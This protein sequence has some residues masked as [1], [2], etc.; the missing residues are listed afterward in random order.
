MGVAIHRINRMKEDGG[1]NS[2]DKQDERGWG[3]QLTG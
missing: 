3:W 2:Q 1:G